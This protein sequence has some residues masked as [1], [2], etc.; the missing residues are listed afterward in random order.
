MRF[1]DGIILLF[2]FVII[3]MLVRVHAHVHVIECAV[4]GQITDKDYNRWQPGDKV[5]ASLSH[6]VTE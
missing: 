6:K 2:L 3:G 4:R 5:C 1:G